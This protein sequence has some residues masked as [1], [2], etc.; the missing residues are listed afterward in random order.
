MDF[1]QT[2]QNFDRQIYENF[3]LQ[4]P[5]TGFYDVVFD[6]KGKKLYAEK[7]RLSIL[8]NTLKSML[9]DRWTS[10]DEPIKI[11]DY[12]FDDFYQ[13]LTFLYT[14]DCNLT[15]DNIDSMV[16]IG[17]YYNVDTLKEA[18]DRFLSKMEINDQN[19]FKL[20]NT[21]SKYSLAKLKESLKTYVATK[22]SI[23]IE[24]NEFMEF[25]KS[26]I[27]DFIILC[28]EKVKPEELFKAV[29]ILLWCSS[30]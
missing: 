29:S 25:N 1:N 22:F 14:G 8:S 5:E 26:N 30:N 23:L 18:C 15:V 19:I 17:E 13:F 3:K 6:I 11:T 4:N 21:V 7:I 12:N 10:K 2:L 20:F 28:K 9:S 24:S 16:D 27:E